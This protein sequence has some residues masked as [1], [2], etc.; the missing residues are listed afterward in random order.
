[1]GLNDL[2]THMN[3]TPHPPALQ[4]AAGHGAIARPWTVTSAAVI[5][6]VLAALWLLAAI[7]CFLIAAD[8]AALRRT[9]ERP[10]VVNG[11]VDGLLSVVFAA[12]LIWGGVRALRGVTS[13]G[14]FFAALGILI[15][16]AI[17]F[18][19]PG[20]WGVVN[21]VLLVTIVA[22]VVQQ[23]S[24]QFFRARGGTAI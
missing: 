16:S 8:L 18:A 19:A 22:L 5:A 23:S 4:P 24:R 1:M 11:F 17:S 14:L 13:K 12:L 21:V 15:L 20:W 7:S 9:A 10:L 2:D 6:F 3:D